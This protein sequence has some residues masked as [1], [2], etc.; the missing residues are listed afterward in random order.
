MQL[1]V[2]SVRHSVP[3]RPVVTLRFLSIPEFFSKKLIARFVQ[4]FLAVHTLLPC[5][6]H[7][8][9]L[10]VH[11]VQVDVCCVSLRF[12]MLFAVGLKV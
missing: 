4:A 2:W 7:S 5:W 10:V 8:A 12:S 11:V 3:R 6:P 9:G 1:S